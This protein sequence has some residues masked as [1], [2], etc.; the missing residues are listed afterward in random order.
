MAQLGSA[1]IG[2]L[3]KLVPVIHLKNTT[4]TALE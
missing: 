3:V 1:P 4:A 2:K